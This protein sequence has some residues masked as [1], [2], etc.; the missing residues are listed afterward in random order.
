M[1]NEDTFIEFENTL[2]ML[3]NIAVIQN[4][5]VRKTMQM[6]PKKFNGK[7]QNPVHQQNNKKPVFTDFDTFSKVD[8]T[9]MASATTA[10]NFTM[11]NK[12]NDAPDK[13]L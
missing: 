1:H 5:C 12:V 3:N 9:K 11:K 2:R 6:G 4:P 8:S 10:S 7:I 13:Q